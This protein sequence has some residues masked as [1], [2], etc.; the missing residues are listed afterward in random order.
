[1]IFNFFY[2]SFDRSTT[3]LHELVYSS[4]SLSFIAFQKF[5]AILEQIRSTCE[6]TNKIDIGLISQ[7]F[8]EILKVFLGRDV[9]RIVTKRINLFGK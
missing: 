8:N 4:S 3:Y 5:I 7:I 9:R 1:M 2:R 6:Y